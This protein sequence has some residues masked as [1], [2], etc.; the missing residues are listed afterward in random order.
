MEHKIVTAQR[1]LLELKPSWNKCECGKC[2]VKE[3]NQ[4]IIIHPNG[5]LIP[6]RI[7]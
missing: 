2:I 5:Q 1:E 3:E 7:S 6:A 4:G